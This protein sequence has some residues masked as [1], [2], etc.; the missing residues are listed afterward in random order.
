MTNENGKGA[1]LAAPS[2]SHD[3]PRSPGRSGFTLLELTIVLLLSAFTIAYA[4]LTFSGYFQRT[5]AQRAA[6]VFAQDLK[7]AR[8]D[9]LRSRQAVV[10]RFDETNL[11]YEVVE[12][13]SGTQ[14]VKRRFGDN[15]EIALSA[16]DLYMRGDSVALNSRGVVSLSNAYGGVGQAR[17]TMGGTRYV[18]YFN[19]LGASK[20]VKG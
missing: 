10:I 3:P 7:K 4:G 8:A 20:V 6:L 14:I 15:A 11:W 13:D 12:E 19:G 17:F 9:A 18:V 16:I 5:S 1:D 2:W